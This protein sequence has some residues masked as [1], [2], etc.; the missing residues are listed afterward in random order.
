MQRPEELPRA[1][2]GCPPASR[3]TS[4]CRTSP[5]TRLVRNPEREDFRAKLEALV[6]DLVQRTIEPCRI[7]L[8]DAGV[9]V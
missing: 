7:A 6:E 2:I 5:L 8:K 4:T 1:K 9:D 3:P